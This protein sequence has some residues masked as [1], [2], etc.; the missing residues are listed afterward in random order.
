MGK[1]II[2]LHMSLDQVVS[3]PENWMVEFS[4]DVLKA[5]MDYYDT[6]D[7][8]IFGSN[9]YP[10]LAEYW[11]T[12]GQHTT[13]TVEQDFA[14]RIN[15][16]PKRVLSRSA[17][18]LN[19][20]NSTWLEFRDTSS[21]LEEIGALKADCRRNISVESGLGVWKLFL[22]LDLFDELLLYI[23]PVLAVHGETFFE[24]ICNKIQLHLENTRTFKNG[25]VELHYTRI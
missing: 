12:A 4:D 14:V 11:Q 13:F 2:H 5:A 1:V 18:E 22:D 17:P 8:V 7:T 24:N 25:I 6:L 3:D 20:Q 15:E 19:W 9:T 16:I 21:F 23:H 10:G